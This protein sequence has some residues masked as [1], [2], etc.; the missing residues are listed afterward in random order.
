MATFAIHFGLSMAH[1][2]FILSRI[3]EEYRRG[4]SNITVS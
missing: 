1:Q 2:V 3:R 4:R